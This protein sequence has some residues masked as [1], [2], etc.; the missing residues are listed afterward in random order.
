MNLTRTFTASGAIGRRRVVKFGAND[1]VVALSTATAD[2]QIGVNE[3]LDVA[4]GDR[5]DVILAGPAT[6]I[7]GGNITRGHDVTTDNAGAVVN[8]APGAGA[9][10]RRIGIAQVNAVAGD[11]FEILVIPALVTTPA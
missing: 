2:F 11:E 5:V 10:G 7:A 8:C 4:D 6:V 1:D 9:S 3:N